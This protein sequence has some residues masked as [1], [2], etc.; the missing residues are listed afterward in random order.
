MLC[1]FVPDGVGFYRQDGAISWKFK[2][3]RWCGVVWQQAQTVVVLAV[4]EEGTVEKDAVAFSMGTNGC[5][6]PNCYWYGGGAENLKNGK[7]D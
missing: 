1:F 2:K 3:K 5:C 7:H 4:T 6:R